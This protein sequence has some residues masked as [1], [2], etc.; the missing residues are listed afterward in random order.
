[1][2]FKSKLKMK[3]GLIVLS[4]GLTLPASAFFGNMMKMGQQMMGGMTQMMDPTQMMMQM[5]G[6]GMGQMAGGAMNMMGSM[7]SM[8]PMGG[9]M[10]QGMSSSAM[11]QVLSN[12]QMTLKAISCAQRNQQMV[13]MMLKTLAGDRGLL[14]QMG[15]TMV[16]DPRIAKAMMDLALRKPQV[17][18]FLLSRIDKVLFNELSYAMILH[19]GMAYDVAHLAWIHRKR[20][21][22]VGS[23]LIQT[24]HAW[25][26]VEQEYDGV[27]FA[28]ERF[29]FAVYSD[30]NAGYLFMKTMAELDET[31]RDYLLDV[32]FLGKIKN[33]FY[34]RRSG[35]WSDA[36]FFNESF[37]N[38]Y[39]LLYG[40]NLSLATPVDGELPA[41]SETGQAL[42]KEMM[43]YMIDHETKRPTEWGMR[44]MLSLVAGAQEYRDPQIG[45]F[46]Q[47]L[48]QTMPPK[49]ARGLPK[50]M[51]FPVPKPDF[52]RFQR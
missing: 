21:L 41:Q 40:L 13:Q 46:A 48:M 10:V 4:V 16:R 1:M 8:M 51:P 36:E 32:I 50:K 30:I 42:M 20:H 2:N 14:H 33:Y 15:R 12:P 38:L 19:Q 6:T 3:L 25:G 47:F 27:E 35:Q 31:T 26:E 37:R 29:L 5:C 7:M 34:D 24:L 22:K 28:T 45:N 44:F 18:D 52:E 23:P 43:K 11:R 39:A 17:G 9:N 49:F